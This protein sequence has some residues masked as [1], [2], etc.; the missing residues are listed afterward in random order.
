MSY[1]T[2]ENIKVTVF[3]QSHS[4]AI[5]VILDGVPPGINIDMDKLNAFIQRRAPGRNQYQTSRKEP[6]IP[7]FLSGITDGVT[8]GAPI[9]AV[10]KNTNTRSKDYKNL[11]DIP[12]PGHADF[13]A[14]VKYQGFNDIRGGGQFSGRMTAPL[15]IAG[16]ILIQILES[17]GIN[18]GAHIYSLN[19]ICDAPFDP[20]NVCKDDFKALKDKE[21]AVIS[22]EAS[23][24]MKEQITEA[25]S[26]GDSVGGV[27]ECAITG[28]PAG[29]GGP[30]FEGLEGKIAQAIFAVPAVKGIEFGAG[31]E[32]ANMLGS[33]HNDPY[34]M[35]NQGKVK[36]KTNNNG[37]ILGGITSGMPVVFRTAIKPT[38]SI[39]KEQDSI[40][41]SKRANKKLI[42]N[43]RHDP[44]I[45]PRAVPVIEAVAAIVIADLLKEI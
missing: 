10:I 28:L 8:C 23:I 14:Y 3:G 25:K 31:F 45:L 15:C 29:L 11:S 7:E 43:G 4:D 33:E 36:T 32:S 9:C 41:I 20:V 6:D 21:L 12:R 26:Q 22:D 2:G 40:S 30:L 44:C 5:G 19:G 34:Y 35:D 27:I 39:A 13:T 37:G 16:G 1:S 38:P 17:M 24:K 18:I 42:I